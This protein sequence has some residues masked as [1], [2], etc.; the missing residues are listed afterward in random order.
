MLNR[1]L[2]PSRSVPDHPGFQ[3]LNKIVE[4]AGT[5]PAMTPVE[6]PDISN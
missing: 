6:V 4:V 3:A 2:A 5:S 1:G